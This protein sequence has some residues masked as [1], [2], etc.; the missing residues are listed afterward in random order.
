MGTRVTLRLEEMLS[1][2]PKIIDRINTL[3][4]RLTADEREVVLRCEVVRYSGEPASDLVEIEVDDDLLD[5]L[6]EIPP[7]FPNQRSSL[8]W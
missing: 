6:D 4:L 3:I 1:Y 7:F 2:G 5:R 8:P